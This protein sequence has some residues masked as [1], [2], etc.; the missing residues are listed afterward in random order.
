LHRGGLLEGP[1]TAPDERV[2]G[3]WCFKNMQNILDKLQPAQV[4]EQT[5]EANPQWAKDNAAQQV[6]RAGSIM[7]YRDKMAEFGADSQVLQWMDQGGFDVRLSERLVRELGA[8]GKRAVG[9]DKQNGMRA[10][11]HEQDLQTV[12]LEALLKGSYEVVADRSGVDNV[13]PANLAPKPSKEPPWRLISNAMAV[14]EFL[15]LWSVRYETLRTVPLVMKQGDWLFMVDL[16]DAYHQFFLTVRSRRLFGH[17]IVFPQALLDQLERAGKLPKDFKKTE[18]KPGFFEVFLRP[19]GLPMGFKNACAIWTKIA[20]VLTAKWRR[21]GKALVH[22]IDDFLFAVDGRLPWEEAC[23]V[24]DAVLADLAAVGA[25]VNWVKSVLSPAKCM[26]FLGMLVDSASYR[27][28]VPEDK[29][30]KLGRLLNEMLLVDEAGGYP[31]AT[32]RE[33]ASVLGKIMSMRIAVP[34]VS[35]M[36]HECYKLLRPEGI[37]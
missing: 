36:T 28:Y 4:E 13:L 7:D 18:V 8:E 2:L 35:M 32:F 9:I 11:E 37:C 16:T 24:R 29:I 33:L 21:E 15:L 5:H 27:F 19:V 12:I 20:R 26:K 10:R 14:N 3:S 6:F 25:Q 31:E 17:R 30:V 34:A 23:K 1:D 22:M